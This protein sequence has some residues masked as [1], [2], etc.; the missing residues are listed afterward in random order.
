MQEVRK[1]HK[2][3]LRAD[4]AWSMNSSKMESNPGDFPGFRHLKAAANSS[5]LKGWEFE[6]SIGLTA[7][8]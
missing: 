1:S 7:A 4:L 2:Q 5:D 3:D 8:C 6:S